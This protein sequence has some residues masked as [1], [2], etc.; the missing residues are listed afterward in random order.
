MDEEFGFSEKQM[1]T[2]AAIACIPQLQRAILRFD[3]SLVRMMLKGVHEQYV[4]VTED[5]MQI[6]SARMR[7]P[8]FTI[9]DAYKEVGMYEFVLD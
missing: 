7:H 1:R 8:T 4:K 5:E 9:H 6:F 3:D 2:I